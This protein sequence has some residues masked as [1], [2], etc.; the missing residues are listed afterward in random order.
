LQY[1]TGGAPTNLKGKV[2]MQVSTGSIE[3]KDLATAFTDKGGR[4]SASMDGKPP[5]IQGLS[6]IAAPPPVNRIIHIRER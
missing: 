2:L 4:K 5:E 6:V 1:N 3:Q